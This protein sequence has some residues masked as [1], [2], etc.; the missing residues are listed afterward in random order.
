MPDESTSQ[1]A[2]L[3]SVLLDP[4]ARIDERDDAAMDLSAFDSPE[5]LDALVRV[6]TDAAEDAIILDS[7]GES[8]AEIWVRKGQIDVEALDRMARPAQHSALAILAGT[9]LMPS[10]R[11]VP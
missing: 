11:L 1:P 7:C 2:G 8:I 6:A 10:G 5:A 9:H 4:S 3:I